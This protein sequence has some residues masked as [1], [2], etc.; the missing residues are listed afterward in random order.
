MRTAIAS[1]PGKVILFGEHFVVHGNPALVSAIDLRAKVEVAETEEGAVLLDGFTGD[2]PATAAAQYLV[3]KLG[4]EKGLRLRISSQIPQSVGLGSSAA[5]AVA[6]AAATLYLIKGELNHRL[7]LEAAY[8]G[9]RVAHYTP[10]GIDTSVAT[11]GGAGSYTRSEGY[12]KLD[13]GLER[14]LIINTGKPRKTGDLVR[15]VRVFSETYPEKFREVLEE[16]AAIAEDAVKFLKSSDL[17]S[18]GKLMN[19]NQE[20]LRLIGVSSKE[21]EEVIQMCL[22]LGAYGAKLTGAGGGGCVIAV[23]DYERMDEFV[24]ALGKRFSVMKTRL[25]EDGVRIEPQPNNP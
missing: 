5:I 16:A 14:L 25:M 24:R 19:R 4:Y 13:I 7:L 15:K 1:A 2:N 9:E 8:E 12:R 23:V 10:S 6:S 3:K 11:F 20:L 18:L 17:E 22:K 21:I